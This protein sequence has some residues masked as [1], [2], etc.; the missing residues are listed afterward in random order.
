M[1]LAR[2]SKGGTI[3][4]GEPSEKLAR[5][6]KELG[7]CLALVRPIDRAGANKIRQYGSRSIHDPHVILGSSL[8]GLDGCLC[9]ACL[10][11]PTVV[12]IQD[13]SEPLEN[14][15]AMARWPAR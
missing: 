15:G 10:S 5:A 14:R 3:N 7:C 4:G 12:R 6:V 11:S 8:L 9:P 2:V 13:G 1:L